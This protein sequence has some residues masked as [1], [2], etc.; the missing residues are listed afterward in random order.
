MAPDRP[1]AED[2]KGPGASEEFRPPNKA[3][4]PKDQK[5]PKP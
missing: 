4:A 2:M 5:A 1:P 3:G